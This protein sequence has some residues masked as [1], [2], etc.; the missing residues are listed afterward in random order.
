MRSELGLERRVHPPRDF[1]FPRHLSSASSSALEKQ[2]AFTGLW[3][4]MVFLWKCAFPT[5][6]RGDHRELRD[7]HLRAQVS[8][9]RPV[10]LPGSPSLLGLNLR[11]MVSVWTPCPPSRRPAPT[12]LDPRVHVSGQPRLPPARCRLP[13]GPRCVQVPL[14]HFHVLLAGTEGSGPR[15]G[16]P[17]CASGWVRLREGEAGLGESCSPAAPQHSWLPEAGGSGARP[18]PGSEPRPDPLGCFS[19]RN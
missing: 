13:C 4:S 17:Q 1:T 19:W 7:E 14:A 2:G 16:S 11:A 15:C 8:G 12:T 6:G 10:A 9:S 3:Q 5:V 18:P